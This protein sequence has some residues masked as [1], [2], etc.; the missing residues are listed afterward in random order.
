MSTGYGA[1]APA[2]G[3]TLL[4]TAS[5]FQMLP[6]EVWQ[7]FK[8]AVK[9]AAGY[10]GLQVALQDHPSI[11]DAHLRFWEAQRTQALAAAHEAANR[12]E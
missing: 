8:R 5:P 10:W 2:S 6:P 12:T 7:G 4:C 9:E 11:Q 3:I 1:G